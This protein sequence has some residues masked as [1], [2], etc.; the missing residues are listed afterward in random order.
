MD[1]GTVE[2]DANGG[3]TPSDASL[4]AQEAS[5]D[6]API[7]TDADAGPACSLPIA[8]TLN[9][10]N[11]TVMGTLRGPS[12][13]MTTSCTTDQGTQG[14]EAVYVLN[15][16]QR[17]GVTLTTDA[18]TNTV[19][20]VR[21]VCDDPVTEVGCNNDGPKP[22]NA[23]LRTILDPG[24]Y[25]VLV[26]VYAFG[27]GGDFTLTLESFAPPTNGTC[28]SATPVTDGAKIQGDLTNAAV[29]ARAISCP[30]VPP[31]PT[32]VLYYKATIPPGNRLVASAQSSMNSMRGPFTVEAFDS[33]TSS[34]C[35][36]GGYGQLTDTNDG[37]TARDVILTVGSGNPPPPP[38]PFPPGLMNT[39]FELDVSIQPLASNATCAA[40]K[41]VSAG[42]MVTGD[43]S[44]GGAD[45]MN[46]C[47]G[48]PFP[49]GFMISNPLWYSVTVP[50]GQVM[51]VNLTTTD[52]FTPFVGAV[53]GCGMGAMCLTPSSG[54]PPGPGQALRYANGDA[55]AKKVLFY[56]G[57]PQGS[58]GGRF[59]FT[60]S[61]DPLASNG[62]CSAP[63]ALTDGVAV[64]GDTTIGSTGS[65][66]CWGSSP[67]M[68][69]YSMTVPAGKTLVAAVK[70]TGM[71]DVHV[72]V[73]DSCN[74]TSCL[75][76]T[77]TSPTGATTTFTN[78]SGAPR[79]V[80]VAVAAGFSGGGAFS[81]TASLRDPPTNVTCGAATPVTNGTSLTF[82]DATAGSDNLANRCLSGDTGGVLYYSAT[83][84]A[85]QTLKATATSSGKWLASLRLL[86]TCG[87]SSCLASSSM[88]MMFPQNALSYTNTSGSPMNVILTVGPMGMFPQSGYFDLDVSIVGPVDGGM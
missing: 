17:T 59:S 65:L 66:P 58:N 6:A 72:G 62:S 60:V 2:P 53:D 44:F 55:S 3:T 45:F 38:G 34:S 28:A 37:A 54:P 4:T 64:Q 48:G 80:I 22:P 5:S 33:C 76:N 73:L 19:L 68:L 46:T 40:A 25:Y 16:A 8:G 67:G 82:Q 12:K 1:A 71:S 15:V 51:R 70:P 63:T 10:P 81:L 21:K 26:D 84:G 23:Q 56:V 83:I 18:T 41:A 29:P 42:A 79:S 9:L 88:P 43:T 31:F 32:G 78:T 13:N 52:P 47:I 77:D 69:Y 85:G 50:A 36:S 27:I 39:S 11:S 86:A 7:P 74:G 24:S 35:R 75:G 14:P 61:I 20:A 30:N 49:P 87:A 57:H